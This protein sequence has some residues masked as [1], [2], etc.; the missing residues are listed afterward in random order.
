ML[1]GGD[2][3]LTIGSMFANR[4]KVLET[5]GRGGMGVVFRA[6]DNQLDEVV[7]L[8]T[9]RSDILSQ[10]PTLLQRFKLEIKLA[11]K[12]THKNVLRTHDFGEF[13]GTPY[14]SM[15][16]LEGV[17]LKDL[18][19]RKGALPLGVGLQIAKQM[20]HGL[21][22]AHAQ[23]VVHRDIKPQNMLIIP[24]TGD[25]KIMDFGIATVSKVEKD[26]K[27]PAD[28]GITGVG[29]VLG[30]PDYLPPELGRGQ[31]ADFRSDIYCMGVVLFE[32]FC[33]RL[34]FPGES[35]LQ[36][37][38]H[39]MQTPPPMPRS[40]KPSIPEDLQAVILRC[41]EKE[42]EKRFQTVDDLT[43]ALNAISDRQAA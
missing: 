37:V 41:L 13:A 2:A 24:E 9:L 3:N 12:I 10:D 1:P 32:L 7:A 15:E 40:I 34:P 8:K 4:Y 43:D 19:K 25:L 21:A 16:Y 5:L 30:T 6:K 26:E 39:H 14:I 20:C 36:I 35:P 27:Q 29:V 42:R 11:R 28:S 38:V 31:Q 23:G 33:G 17:T 22:A 18:Q